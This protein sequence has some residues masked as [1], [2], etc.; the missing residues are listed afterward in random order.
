MSLLEEVQP[1][2]GTSEILAHARAELPQKDELCGAFTGLISLRAHGF[3]VSDQDEVARAAGSVLLAAGPS[4]R[5]PGEPGRVDFRL[6]LPST[7]D[8][9]SAGTSAAGVARAV[10]T[11]SDGALAVVPACGQWSTAVVLQVL[12][13]LR[14][15]TRVAVIANV[16]T[17]A[18]AAPDTPGRALR[19]YL[20][21]GLAPLWMNLWR[22]GHF[23]VLSGI[24]PGRCG[25]LVSVVDTYPSL[26]QRG[27]HLQPVEYV[28]AALRRDGMAPGGLLVVV[29]AG[30]AA[31]A[32]SVVTGA[33]LHATLW[34]NGSPA[35]LT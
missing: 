1:L 28:A 18:F 11:L 29:P 31:A 30:D 5:P 32:E 3:P 4:S 24:L 23:V 10:E 9:A 26:G 6:S 19:D 22:V 20:D 15:L 14:T 8:P 16:D 12:G 33:G 21:S 35:P 34:D 17:G 2:P 25:T 27:V 13:G 7:R